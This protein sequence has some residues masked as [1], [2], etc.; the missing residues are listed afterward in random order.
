MFRLSEP[1]S[2]RHAALQAA[3]ALAEESSTIHTPEQVIALAEWILDGR[4]AEVDL[5]NVGG[6]FGPPV[7]MSTFERNEH[8][9]GE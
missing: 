2:Q 1:Q 5:A 8:L 7:E 3:L 4:P 9:R 6:W